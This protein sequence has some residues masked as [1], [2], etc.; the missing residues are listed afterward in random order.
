M[1]DLGR[2]GD[3][4]AEQWH[5][6][7]AW[8]WSHTHT[9]EVNTGHFWRNSLRQIKETNTSKVLCSDNRTCENQIFFFPQNHAICT[10]QGRFPYTYAVYSQRAR[11]SL[12]LSNCHMHVYIS[13][14]LSII[15]YT[16]PTDE[17]PK[18]TGSQILASLYK[19]KAGFNSDEQTP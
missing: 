2:C 11:N 6:C 16:Y 15:T 18:D 9:A 14:K 1:L 8:T 13:L 7:R 5:H 4:A 3:R 10:S 17:L 12:P 19:V